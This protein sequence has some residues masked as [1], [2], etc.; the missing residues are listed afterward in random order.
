MNTADLCDQ[1]GAGV[2]ILPGDW[3]WFGARRQFSGP[4]VTLYALGCNGEIR[5]LLAQPGAGRVLVIEAGGDPGAL[6]GDRLGA[7]ALNNGWAGVLV[8]GNVRDRRVLAGLDLGILALGS[9]P[10]RS[11]NREGGKVDVPL[12]LGGVSVEPGDWLYADED[13][14]LLA[15]EAL[16]P[17]NR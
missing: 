3:Q 14:V 16:D 12:L 11:H 1:H 8:N 13:G 15:R 6:L 4:V 10:Q 17:P 7:L 9:W 5:Q 2:R